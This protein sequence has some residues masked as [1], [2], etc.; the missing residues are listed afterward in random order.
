LG[1]EDCLVDVRLLDIELLV[2]GETKQEGIFI[3]EVVVGVFG[4]LGRSKASDDLVHLR[5]DEDQ[6]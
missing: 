1:N 2:L 3:G 6:E 4:D 5:A